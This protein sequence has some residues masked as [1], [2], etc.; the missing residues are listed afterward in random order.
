MI[1]YLVINNYKFVNLLI[2]TNFWGIISTRV[3]IKICKGV[4]FLT[5]LLGI[6][7]IIAGVLLVF[8]QFGNFFYLNNILAL[9][10][11]IVSLIGIARLKQKKGLKSVNSLMILFGIVLSI[12]GATQGFRESLI[13]SWG[14]LLMLLGISMII[15]RTPENTTNSVEFLEEEDT[16]SFELNNNAETL[17]ERWSEITKEANW[18][19]DHHKEIKHTEAKPSETTEEKAERKWFAG[20]VGEQVKSR[21][22]NT[23]FV[24]NINYTNVNTQKLKGYT[25]TSEDRLDNN[26]I[27]STD[28]QIYKSDHFIGGKVSTILSE[29]WLDLSRVEAQNRDVRLDTSVLFSTLN[30]RIPEDWVVYVSG[31]SFLATTRIPDQAPAEAKNRL[32]IK[33]SAA[34]GTLNV[35]YR[36]E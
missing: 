18:N 28:K 12:V 5:I 35:E 8:A 36:K 33:N 4:L 1:Y 32:I 25:V 3:I 11:L 31:R 19:F 27:L 14:A 22:K 13:L 24:D 7:I 10:P 2:Y 17:D 30:I 16:P 21:K 29:F 15:S 26:V 6:F 20:V 34:F 9:W 23:I